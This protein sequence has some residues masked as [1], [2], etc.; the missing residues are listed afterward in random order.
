MPQSKKKSMN[1]STQGTGYL[2]RF[3]ELLTYKAEKIGKKVI[4][5]SE[6]YTTKKCSQCGKLHDMP[7]SKRVMDCDCG[8][9]IDR[10]KN[11][12]VNIMVEAL[13]QN[14]KCTGSYRDAIQCFVENLRTGAGISVFSGTHKKPHA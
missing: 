3:A 4:E 9:K 1:R 7:V 8:L 5:V 10:D 2:A 11:S 14:A 12:A 6:R 13:S